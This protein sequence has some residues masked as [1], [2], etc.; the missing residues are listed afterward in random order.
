[1][2][3]EEL[4]SIIGIVGGVVGTLVSGA[5]WVLITVAKTFWSLTFSKLDER[6]KLLETHELKEKGNHVVRHT[7]FSMSEGL[8]NH[9][10]DIDEDIESVKERLSLSE[11][12]IK[13]IKL[14]NDKDGK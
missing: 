8:S 2:T 14:S 7:F 6:V 13:I 4:S 9:L 1:M 11:T 12:E 10:K 5:A 3:L